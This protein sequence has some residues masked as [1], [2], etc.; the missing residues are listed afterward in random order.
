[1]GLR[2]GFYTT[3]DNFASIRLY[4]DNLFSFRIIYISYLPTG[5]YSIENG[6]LILSY[7]DKSELLF[8]IGDDQLVFIGA[9]TEGAEEGPLEAGTIFNFS[10]NAIQ[11]LQQGIYATDD[12]MA[13]VT[14]VDDNKYIFDRHSGTSYRPT[15]N[16]TIVNGKLTLYIEDKAE[17]VFDI[18]DGQLV[19]VSGNLAEFLVA[20]GTIFKLVN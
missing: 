10:E 11:E 19:F 7:T 18:N 3:D 14:L 20:T 12:G 8:E 4:G 6:K 1:M 2:Q 15:G 16:Y 5:S 17:F 9:N 13:S